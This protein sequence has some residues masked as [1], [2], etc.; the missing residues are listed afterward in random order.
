M[1]LMLATHGIVLELSGLTGRFCSLDTCPKP[2]ERTGGQLWKLGPIPELV[3]E[4]ELK[5]DPR[6]GQCS[7]SE[8]VS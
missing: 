3:P 4:L 6:S 5:I 8:V 2:D 7:A 1:V